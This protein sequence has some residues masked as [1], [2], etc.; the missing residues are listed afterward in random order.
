MSTVTGTIEAVSTKYDKF[1]VLVD[2]TWYGTKQEWAPDPLPKTGDK[3]TFDN[4]GKKFLSKCKVMGS[5]GGG[6]AA[7]QGGGG[8]N[9][10]N[11]GVEVGHASN[12]AMRVTEMALREGDLE[13]A[14]GSEDFYRFF[15]K[16][17]KDIYKLMA[18][19]KKSIDSEESS[20]ALLE[21]E[22]EARNKPKSEVS[23][24]DLF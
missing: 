17:S 6:G 22:K 3:I 4:G 15:I 7:P 13:T 21:G 16:Q 24:K 18:A 23:D 1:S 5:G 2:G 8:K 20:A 14:V 11:L 9:N 12:L 19:L 10:W